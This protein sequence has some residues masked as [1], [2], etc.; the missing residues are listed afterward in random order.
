MRKTK[1]QLVSPRG[2]SGIGKRSLPLVHVLL[3]TTSA[4]ALGTA[5][6]A[7]CDVDP[8]TPYTNNGPI[9]CVVFN[10]NGANLGAYPPGDVTNAS[11]ATI[12]GST[13]N[14]SLSVT[15][16][17]ITGNI[18]NNGTIT[19]GSGRNAIS[20]IAGSV[21]GGITN[22]NAINGAGNG[23]LL[24][25]VT[26]SIATTPANV[27]GSINNSGTIS[28]GGTAIIINS[29]ATV[30]SIVNS[31][32]IMPGSS[33]TGAAMI[34]IAPLSASPSLDGP[35]NPGTVTGNITNSGTIG[36][37]TAASII[38]SGSAGGIDNTASG[39]ITSNNTNGVAILVGGNL[40]TNGAIQ[41]GITNAG[42]ISGF[43]G[44]DV[45]N[46]TL[47]GPITN[48]GNI[49]AP[50]SGAAID[51]APTGTGVDDTSGALTAVTINQN[52]GNIIGNILLS[53]NG[54]TVNIAGGTLNGDIQGSGTINITGGAI[55]GGFIQGSSTINFNLGSGSFTFGVAGVPVAAQVS[56]I[57]INTGTVIFTTPDV[58]VTGAVTNNAALEFVDTGVQHS[59]NGNYVQG[60]GGNLIVAVTPNPSEATSQFYVG[61]NA[62]LAGTVTFAYAPGTYTA[63]TGSGLRFLQTNAN[64]LTGTFSTVSETGTPS[65]LSEKVNYDTSDAY[66][67]LGTTTPPPPPP[68]PP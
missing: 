21:T 39:T 11:S 15:D 31:G 35:N 66:L 29:G 43:I 34:E 53:S 55:T 20:V 16:A 36:S 56:A 18:V 60:A 5:A 44:I 51:L 4:L 8:T 19:A 28:V 7:A 63:T 59:I 30:G 46:A 22:T 13:S 65:G 58:Q 10:G 9:A 42:A 1:S 50:A 54:D 2:D 24:S 62:S 68:P 61:G 37:G 45:Q 26:G 3:A 57:N 23:I 12:T 6:Q 14:D 52:G 67:A 25:A 17:I 48:T 64:G 41:N 38:V 27:G 33:P 49:T 40:F 47:G 32:S